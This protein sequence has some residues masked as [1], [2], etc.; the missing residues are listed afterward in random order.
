MLQYV[1]QH[2]KY[3]ITNNSSQ[4][5]ARCGVFET[6]HGIIQTPIFMPVGTLASVKGLS[7]EE[8]SD[9]GAQIVLANTY[10]L[11]LRPGADIVAAAGGLHK[12]MNWNKP[13]LTDSGGFQVFSLADM[14]KIN[15]NGVEFKSHIDGQAF[16]FT[17]ENNI[18]VQNKLGAD[19]IMQLDICVKYDTPKNDVKKALDQTAE[20][21]A[22]AAKHHTNPKQ[23]LFPIIQ[24][25]FD[26]DLRLESL[27]LA[28]PYAKHGIAIGGIAIDEPFSELC[29]VL[30]VL[31]PHLPPE[32]P[33]YLMGAG[34]PDYILE[35]VA[36]G[37]DM[38]DCVYQ[39]RVARNGLA[40]TN[41]GTLNLR[42][43][44]FKSDFTP[45][46]SEC[47][48]Y[49]CKNYTKAYVR[50]LL[51]ANEMFACRL[52]SIHNIHW[53]MKFMQQIRESIKNDTFLQFRADFYKN[54]YK[55][56]APALDNAK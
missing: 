47:D 43:A 8:V 41:N 39:T 53:T 9:A 13:I 36:R 35:A 49:A 55:T 20:W 4:C 34:T 32:I 10:H 1:M 14:R 19:I 16:L 25:G 45:I 56:D 26:K 44:K 51:I 22:R 42:N 24:G 33:H 31:A 52:L 6:P 46:D 17:P 37:V 2:F 29:K 28:L 21:L 30:D 38:F 7:P 54:Y 18:D 48:C 23:A 40:M 11:F 5:R 15:D 50:H 27:R 3:N 12:F